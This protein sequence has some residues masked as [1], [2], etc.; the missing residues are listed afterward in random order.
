MAQYGF[1]KSHSTQHATLDIIN[2]IQTNMDE[3]LFTSGVFLYLRKAFDMHRRSRRV[4][5]IFRGAGGG[6]GCVWAVKIQTCR[7]VRV[8]APPGKF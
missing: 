6:G 4:A 7:G 8:Y 5:R 1:R 3:G 2:S